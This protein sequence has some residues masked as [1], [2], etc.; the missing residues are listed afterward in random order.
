M[1]MAKRRL[2]LGRGWARSES[3]FN[4]SGRFGLIRVPAAFVRWVNGCSC[5]KDKLAKGA[6][7]MAVV[8]RP[9]ARRRRR[10]AGRRPP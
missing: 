4:D 6:V 10:A 8:S 2:Q 7:A 3:K 5:A 9:E 1:G